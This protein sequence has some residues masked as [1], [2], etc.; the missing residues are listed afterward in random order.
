MGAIALS[1]G[2]V[3]IELVG[4]DL[5]EHVVAGRAEDEQMSFSGRHGDL[6]R[7]VAL[8]GHDGLP[9]RK[10]FFAAPDRD[11]HDARPWQRPISHGLGHLAVDE[12]AATDLDVVTGRGQ[13]RKSRG[14]LVERETPSTLPLSFI[15]PTLETITSTP[16]AGEPVTSVRRARTI[17]SG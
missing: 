9:A 2:T 17:C 13:T 15:R 3:V 10:H 16:R 11:E 4:A 8:A 1:A 5:T 14:A 6:E 12:H 7:A